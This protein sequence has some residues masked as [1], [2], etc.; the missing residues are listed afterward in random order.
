MTKK[1]KRVLIAGIGGASLGTE[2]AKCLTLA[3]R[4][5]VYG[6]DIS[7]LAY[8]HYLTDFQ[9]T[10]LVERTGYVDSVIDLCIQEKIDY[11]VPGGEEPMLLLGMA[12]NTLEDNGIRLAGNSLEVIEICS[13]KART[14]QYLLDLGLPVPRTVMISATQ[15]LDNMSFPCIIK[16]AVHSGGSSFVFLAKD[17]EE[18]SIY[19]KYLV[20]NSLSPIAQEYIPHDDGEFTVGVLS[21]PDG[22]MVGSIALKR[23]FN[24]KLSVLMKGEAGLIS[25]GYSQGFINDFPEVRKTAENI[26]QALSSVGPINVQGRVKDGLF[27]PFEVNPRFSASTYLRALAGF[28]ELDIYL[29]YQ[30]TGKLSPP[31]SLR[32]GYYLRSLSETFVDR[33]DLRK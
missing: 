18:A 29:Q 14:F 3:D 33:E 23:L 27:I 10:F 25:S 15:Q 12:Q 24:A 22:R 16:P 21:L 9:K 31:V 30:A 28:N 1:S 6:C 8:G 5:I 20:E 17:K 4:Y 32:Y 11:V 2:L 13:D 26:A 19:A 7:P